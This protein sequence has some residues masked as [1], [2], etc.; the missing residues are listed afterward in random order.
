MICLQRID[1]RSFEIYHAV[2]TADNLFLH[3][4]WNQMLENY[5]PHGNGYLLL[6][7]DIPIGGAVIC[8]G[9]ITSPYLIPPLDDPAE[10]MKQLLQLVSNDCSRIE[11]AYI[12][13]VF[14]TALR[15]S[16]ACK[17]RSKC[18]MIRP[19]G[20]CQ[21]ELPDVFYFDTV[22][23]SEKKEMVEVIFQAH[24]SGYTAS[25]EGPLDPG[26]VEEVLQ[27]RLDIFS[28]NHTLDMGV[29]VKEWRTNQIVG[30]C[31]AGKYPD[32]PNDFSTIH[33]LA[34]HPSFQRRGIATAMI[35]QVLDTA[36]KCSPVILLGVLHG[37]PAETL[38][39]KLGFRRGPVYSDYQF[40][41]KRGQDI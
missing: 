25:V 16:G 31:I 24:Q 14:E 18:Q 8:A 29:V 7:D 15:E 5:A 38:Y 6:K 28:S 2:Y 27:Q 32:V 26:C 37:N 17:T 1:D 41:Q 4:D 36:H 22:K 9:K 3:Y 13:E 40:D 11:L 33:Q 21:F 30:V 39:H 35:R 34:V 19:T 20:V 23:L 10:F 12:P